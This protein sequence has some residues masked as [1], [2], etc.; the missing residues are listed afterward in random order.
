MSQAK[1]SDANFS[2]FRSFLWPIH[3]FELKKFV[4]MQLMLVLICFNYS[5]L[6]SLKDAV[7]ITS[8]GSELI[9]FIKMLVLLP[10]AILLTVVFARLSDRYSQERVFYIMVSFFISFFALFTYVLYPLQDYIHPTESAA[11]LKLLFPSFKWFIVLY[12]NWS[13]VLFYTMS[14]LWS[15]MILNVIFWGFANE[16][17]RIYEARRFYSVFSI[18]SNIAAALA[19]LFV[20]IVISMQ[21][22]QSFSIESIEATDA[23]SEAIWQQKFGWLIG[24]IIFCSFIIMGLFRWMNKNVLT[25]ASFDDL[26]KTKKVTRAKGKQSLRESFQYLKNSKYLVFIAIL[27]I[28]Y[29]FSIHMVELVWKD[30][31]KELY[32]AKSDFLRFMGYLTLSMGVVSTL[33]SFFMSR[34][35]SRFGWTFTAMITPITMLMTS[36]S[37][38][39]FF[40]FRD[41]LT[42]IVGAWGTTP[43]AIAVYIGFFHNCFCKAAKYSVFDAT[44][45]MAFIPLDHESKLKG[46][47]AI[48]GVGSRLGKSGGSLIHAGLLTILHNLSNSSPIVAV[49]LLVVIVG[50]IVATKALG[51][52]FYELVGQSADMGSPQENQPQPQE[53]AKITI[54]EGTAPAV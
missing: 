1:D 41:S 8:S 38:F 19:G 36:V 22:G 20:I 12:E 24:L 43:L 33:T 39:T 9:P 54:A 44:I 47:A 16:V 31:V 34:I 14:E 17:T 30:Q 29:N 13:F 10:M 3:R 26:H 4:P 42:P 6:R 5:I 25:D 23:V 28:S 37:F 18:S 48:D 7:V 2:Y 35:L 11:R 15:T 53:Q 51:G 32:P 45:N 50:W 52:K 46:K 49:L 21:S 40:F 27:V